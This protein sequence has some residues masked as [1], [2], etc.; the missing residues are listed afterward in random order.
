[1]PLVIINSGEAAGDGGEERLLEYMCDYP[2]CPNR[3][4][5]VIGFV[6]EIG[7]GFAVCLRH[8]AILEGRIGRD[9]PRVSFGDFN[10]S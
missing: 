7:G 3:A 9:L 10:S 5:R 1:M 2:N 4:E 6:R 8:A